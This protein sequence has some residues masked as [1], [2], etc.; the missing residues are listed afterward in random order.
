MVRETLSKRT[1]VEA[2][3]ITESSYLSGFRR[4]LS[5]NLGILSRKKALNDLSV[6]KIHRLI[7]PV[8]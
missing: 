5:L 1:A 3:D 8:V 4:M 2:V 7:L 6:M